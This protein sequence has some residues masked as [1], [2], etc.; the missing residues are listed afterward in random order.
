MRARWGKVAKASNDKGPFKLVRVESYG[1]E[2]VCEVAEVYGMQGSPPEGSRM[3]LIPLEGDE[4]KVV[5]IPMVPS[6]ERFDAQKEGEQTM[7]HYKTKNR[8]THR[9]NGNTII[10]TKGVLYI[11]SDEGEDA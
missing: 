11:N 10:K 1:Q 9:N 7:Q 3:L 4:G 8:V 6:A 2:Q 5:G